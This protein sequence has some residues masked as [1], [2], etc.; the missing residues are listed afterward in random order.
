H[1]V[2]SQVVDRRDRVELRAGLLAGEKLALA[3]GDAADVLHDGVEAAPRGERPD[4]AERAERDVD[5][6]GPRLGE[7]LGREAAVAERAGTV[8]LDE[9][10]GVAGEVLEGLELGRVAQVELGRELA[11]AGVEFLVA[12]V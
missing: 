6:A 2:A 9:D 10:V 4:M 5:E 11:V 7:L 8:A 1:Q 12:E 3:P